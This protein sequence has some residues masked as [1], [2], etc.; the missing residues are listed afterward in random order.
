MDIALSVVVGDCIGSI[1]V[2]V[3]DF[4]HDALGHIPVRCHKALL[5]L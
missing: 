5:K 4:L 1:P 3:V 2:P